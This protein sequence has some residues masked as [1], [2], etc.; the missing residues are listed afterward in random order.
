M[1]FQV[2][3]S[4]VRLST[5]GSRLIGSWQGVGVRKEWTGSTTI[6]PAHRLYQR[7]ETMTGPRVALFRSAETDRVINAGQGLV[8]PDV[9]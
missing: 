2:F 4:D 9:V 5:A 1:Q 7:A 6:G 3:T 8:S